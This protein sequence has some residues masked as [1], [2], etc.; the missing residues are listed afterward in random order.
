MIP[1]KIAEEITKRFTKKSKYFA[2]Q[3]TVI[4]PEANSIFQLNEAITLEKKNLFKKG[5]SNYLQEEISEDFLNK[6]SKSIFTQQNNRKVFSFVS[7][8]NLNKISYT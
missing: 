8:E 2:K 6:L 7:F 3:F 5:F 1:Y 4:A